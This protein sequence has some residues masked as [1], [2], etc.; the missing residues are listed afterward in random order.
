M[1]TPIEFNPDDIKIPKLKE[2]LNTSKK[3]REY[4]RVLAITRKPKMNEFRSI[5]KVTGLGMIV[6]GLIDF[7]IFIIVQLMSKLA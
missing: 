3:A 2:T 1:V 6:I 5:V 7:I 4:K